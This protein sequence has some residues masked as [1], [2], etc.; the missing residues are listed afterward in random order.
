MKNPQYFI[1]DLS[2][3]AVL[4]IILRKHSGIVGKIKERQI[5][6]HCVSKNCVN[7]WDPIFYGTLYEYENRTVVS[8]EF[9]I[10]PHIKAGVLFG[11]MFSVMLI[12]FIFIGFIAGNS[13]NGSIGI[14]G[15]LL[16]SSVFLLLFWFS[17]LVEKIGRSLG[18]ETKKEIIRFIEKELLAN[19]YL[20]NLK[21]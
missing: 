2:C 7:S 8:G 14:T 11:R 15:V 4:E 5:E 3:D 1:T 13:Y 21:G 18:E 19:P 17:F 9:H 16:F 12:A 20:P 6:I 10:N